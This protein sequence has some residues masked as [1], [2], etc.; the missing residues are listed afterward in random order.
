MSNN[1]SVVKLTTLQEGY[2]ER[3]ENKCI[4]FYFLKTIQPTKMPVFEVVC[5]CSGRM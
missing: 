5:K 2:I 3:F 4:F 1:A